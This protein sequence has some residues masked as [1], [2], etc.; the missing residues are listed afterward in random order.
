MKMLKKGQKGFT[1]IELLIVVAIIGI[2]AAI[3]IPQFSAYRQRAYNGSA[4][5][6]LRN[7]KTAE[8]SLLADAQAYGATEVA[9][10][11]LANLVGGG[12]AGVIVTGPLGAATSAVAGANLGGT[13]AQGRIVGIGISISNGVSVS[14]STNAAFGTTYTLYAK[15]T[16]GTRAFA[17]EAENTGMFMVENPAWAGVVMTGAIP[18][19]AAAPTTAAEFSSGVTPG[20]GK[21]TDF[22]YIM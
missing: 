10:L 4:Q 18:T 11:T 2:L 22:W 6:D 8:E 1:L 9:T 14:A 5:S 7:I 17:T 21:P 16:S 20:G 13:T 3:A 19:P 15:H 12:G